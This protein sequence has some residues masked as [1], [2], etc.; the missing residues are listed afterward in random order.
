MSLVEDLPNVIMSFISR[1]AAYL[2]TYIALKRM[3]VVFPYNGLLC[4]LNYDGLK[5]SLPSKGA[6][7]V[8]G[9]DASSHIDL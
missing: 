2:A 3:Y 1:A 4:L 7:Q 9:R 6:R 8:M 5:P